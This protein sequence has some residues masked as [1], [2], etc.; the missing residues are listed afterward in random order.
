[1]I[2]TILLTFFGCQ[3]NN[4]TIKVHE[5]TEIEKQTA[6]TDLMKRLTEECNVEFG[7]HSRKA[8]YVCG[9]AVSTESS[10]NLC[11]C[12]NEAKPSYY[13]KIEFI[14]NPLKEQ[15]IKESRPTIDTII[16]SIACNSGELLECAE[17]I[18]PYMKKNSDCKYYIFSGR[19]FH[20][21]EC[22]VV[23]GGV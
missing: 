21:W 1:M 13:T 12:Y 3:D 9:I 4:P 2:N 23:R 6:H 15:K 11:V 22:S 7:N 5:A 8:G 18:Q 20:M 16:Y 14:M 10:Y 19:K 17:A